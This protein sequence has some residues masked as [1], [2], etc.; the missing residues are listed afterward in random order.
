MLWKANGLKANFR[1][2][3]NALVMTGSITEDAVIKVSFIY[4]FEGTDVVV[5]FLLRET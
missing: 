5:L 2:I 4:F 3:Y 1:C